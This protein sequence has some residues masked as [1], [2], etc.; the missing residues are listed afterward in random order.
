ME[1]KSHEPKLFFSVVVE[2]DFGALGA[3]GGDRERFWGG[4]NDSEC[5][6]QLLDSKKRI[7][8]SRWRGRLTVK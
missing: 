3:F 4:A 6:V 1:M 8:D 2:N 5:T 7:R